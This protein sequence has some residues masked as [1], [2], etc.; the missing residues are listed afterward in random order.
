ML[1]CS[2]VSNGGSGLVCVI[3]GG[4][5]LTAPV[6]RA[7]R[8]RE[9]ARGGGGM[10]AELTAIS[11]E[12][13]A[14]SGRGRSKRGGE[15]GSPAADNMDEDDGVASAVPRARASSWGSMASRRSLWPARRGEGEAMA[16]VVFVG[17]GDNA[18]WLCPRE[19][20]EE[21]SSGSE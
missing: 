9:R 7:A 2:G 21:R 8:V 10:V 18:W 14:G 19:P 5:G 15:A 16:M 13:S 20:V 4:E 3:G 1:P 11:T 6:K 12:E 17:A